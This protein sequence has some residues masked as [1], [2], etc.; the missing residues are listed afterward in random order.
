M[1]SDIELELKSN[2]KNR[3]SPNSKKVLKKGEIGL[4][5]I[6]GNSG[7]IPVKYAGWGTKAPP[8]AVRPVG[9]GPGQILGSGAR[10]DGAL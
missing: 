1:K 9:N 5:T 6:R 7:P 4:A 2:F 8:L 3:R 10:G